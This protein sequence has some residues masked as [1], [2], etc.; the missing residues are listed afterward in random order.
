MCNGQDLEVSSLSARQAGTGCMLEAEA[1]TLVPE[2]GA[3]AKSGISGETR[4]HHASRGAFLIDLACGGLLS[5]F[6]HS[7]CVFSHRLR[8]SALT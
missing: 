2:S 5:A 7:T 3:R 8:G 6:D 4:W 1:T